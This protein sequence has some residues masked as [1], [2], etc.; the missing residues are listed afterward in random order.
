MHPEYEDSRREGVG[1]REYGVQTPG[2][3]IDCTRY[4]GVHRSSPYPFLFGM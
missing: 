1:H 3:G 4:L 2:D